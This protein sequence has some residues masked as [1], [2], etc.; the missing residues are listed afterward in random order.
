MFDDD[1]D[2]D[3][4]KNK[5]NRGDD[6]GEDVKINDLLKTVEYFRCPIL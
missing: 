6:N 5:D 1:D 3:E 4:N 2:S